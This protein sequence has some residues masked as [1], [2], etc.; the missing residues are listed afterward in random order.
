MIRSFLLSL[1][2]FAGAIAGASAK[3]LEVGE[4]KQFKLVSEAVK[5]AGEGDRIAIYP[6]EY[7][8]CAIV[9]QKGLTIEGV[10]KAEDIVMTDKSCQGKAILVLNAPNVTVRNITLTR[11]RVP[12]ANGAGIRQEGP[13]LTIEHVRFINNQ[14]GILSGQRGGTTIIRDSLFERNGGCERACSHGVYM[15]PVD[16]LRIERSRFYGTKRA[17]HIKSGAKRTEVIDCD[18]ED[19]PDGTAS[20][21]IDIPYGGDLVVRNTT[22]VKGPRAE[23]HKYAI[24][25]AEDGQLQR[26]NEI[27]IENNTFRNEGNWET[28]FVNN[29]TA[30]EAILR[31]NKLFGSV[32]PLRGD[33]TVEPPE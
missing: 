31:N 32:V 3:T 13:D 33:G 23:N 20:Y 5:A 7:F 19:G 30:A 2:V 1:L 24:T 14:D 10:G 17:H 29:V 9:Y 16:L 26:T 4:G 11:S 22:M 27:L 8:D 28:I 6:G 15:G 12:D 25:I 21:E 18:I